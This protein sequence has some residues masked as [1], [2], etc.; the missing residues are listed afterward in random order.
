MQFV[1]LQFSNETNFIIFASVSH[2]NS[3]K[4]INKARCSWSLDS[5]FRSSLFYEIRRYQCKRN[6]P[7]AA[8]TKQIQH[9][10]SRNFRGGW[11]N[12]FK[13]IRGIKKNQLGNIKQPDCPLSTTV[14]VDH[15]IL[16]IVKKNSSQ[17]NSTFQLA[18]DVLMQVD[19]REMTLW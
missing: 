3:F 19:H 2:H 18:E 5:H 9:C 11:I 4:K 7:P 10:E 14:V 12:S 13:T 16:S 8:T 6:R 17:L 1:S 15:R